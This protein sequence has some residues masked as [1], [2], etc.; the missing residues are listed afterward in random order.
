VPAVRRAQPLHAIGIFDANTL[1]RRI[2]VMTTPRITLTM[3]RR[4]ACFAACL[5]LAGAACGSALALSLDVKDTS[6]PATKPLH[7]DYSKVN[8]IHRQDPVYPAEARANKDTGNGTCILHLVVDETGTPVS[9]NIAKSLR[10]DYDISALEAVRQWRWQPYLLN[11]KP[12]PI[13]IDVAINY[14]LY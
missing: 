7:I 8:I 1:E 14:S 9:I 4:I 12:V 5:V 13:D 10:R 3:T 2:T 11:G 6:G